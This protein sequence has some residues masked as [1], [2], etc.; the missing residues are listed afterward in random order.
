MFYQLR[1]W[2]LVTRLISAKTII[3]HRQAS[4]MP[5]AFKNNSSANIKL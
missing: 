3:A 5:K 4:R 2:I 1:L